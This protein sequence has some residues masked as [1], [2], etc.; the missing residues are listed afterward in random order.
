M[1]RTLPLPVLEALDDAVEN[2]LAGQPYGVEDLAA[3]AAGEIRH[4]R[5]QVEAIAA[6][7]I[8]ATQV[9]DEWIARDA[10]DQHAAD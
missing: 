6:G 2:G 4:L 10:A 8:Y 9:R 5:E 3:A 1:P 7:R